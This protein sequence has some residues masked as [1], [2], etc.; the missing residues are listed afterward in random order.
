MTTTTL[1]WLF[2]LQ[3]VVFSLFIFF[4][5]RKFQKCMRESW[6]KLEEDY[7]KLDAQLIALGYDMRDALR[8]SNRPNSGTTGRPL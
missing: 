1:G 8:E 5:E 6:Q 4:A 7:R 3:I 2:A